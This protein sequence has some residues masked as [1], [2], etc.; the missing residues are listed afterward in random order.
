MNEEK[1]HVYRNYSFGL[2]IHK[3]KEVIL[4]VCSLVLVL[5]LGGIF[6]FSTIANFFKNNSSQDMQELSNAN[7]ITTQSLEE[8]RQ[9]QLEIKKQEEM[10]KIQKYEAAGIPSYGD[11]YKI[12]FTT[13]YVSD[14]VTVIISGTNNQELSKAQEKAEEIISEAKKTVEIN[15]ISYKYPD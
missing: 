13:P 11:N 10:T 14:Q 2:K 8:Q 6:I 12:V 5:F 15:Q 4:L 7:E 3:Q 9:A 1:R